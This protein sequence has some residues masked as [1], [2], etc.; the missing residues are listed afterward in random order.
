MI[1]FLWKSLPHS[2]LEVASKLLATAPLPPRDPVTAVLVQL[3]AAKTTLKLWTTVTPS[4]PAPSLLYLLECNR[5]FGYTKAL[6]HDRPD[7]SHFG[8]TLHLMH[9]IPLNKKLYT[10]SYVCLTSGAALVFSAIYPLIDIW[11]LKYM[12]LPLERIG[13]N[14]MFVY[15]MV[16]EGIF[17]GFSSGWQF[18]PALDLFGSFDGCWFKCSG[19]MVHSRSLMNSVTWHLATSKYWAMIDLTLLIFGTYSASSHARRTMAMRHFKISKI[20]TCSD[21]RSK[22]GLPN[23][24]VEH[25]IPIMNGQ[26]SM[27]LKV[28]DS[29]SQKWKLRYYTRPNGKK[30]GPIF[31][32]GWCRFVETNRLQVG[33]ELTFCGHQVRAADGKLK[34]KYM[35]EVKRIISMTFKGEPLTSNVEYLIA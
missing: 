4:L 3:F 5:A 26:H 32:T 7:S 24:M 30:K 15:V 28:V 21:I 6:G 27:D 25:M 10:S 23:D 11:D 18:A 16:A 13:M 35:I 22:I 12:F 2:Q 31:T 34:M 20:L 17:A 14:T 19:E 33:D 8:L 9:A 29:R 1:S